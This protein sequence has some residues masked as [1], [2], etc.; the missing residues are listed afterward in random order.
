MPRPAARNAS[1]ASARIGPWPRASTREDPLPKLALKDT[2]TTPV[3]AG[4][5]T[6]NVWL[7]ETFDAY[8]NVRP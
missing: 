8:A 3:G 5:R 6:V 4:F 1:K 7:R 2:L